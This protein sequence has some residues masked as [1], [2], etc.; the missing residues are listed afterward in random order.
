MRSLPSTHAILAASLAVSGCVLP[1]VGDGAFSVRGRVPSNSAGAANCEVQLA[2]A[3]AGH[4]I[5]TT[6]VTGAF[7]VTFVV[8][9]KAVTYTVL[10]VCDGIVRQTLQIP[11][12]NGVGPGGSVRLPE[13]AT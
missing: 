12:G 7:T 3:E 8:A 1:A 5:E 13:I 11:Y 9:P 2:D 10:T 6:R 4:V